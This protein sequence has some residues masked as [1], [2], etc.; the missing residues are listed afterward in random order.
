VAS[1]AYTVEVASFE[2]L[3]ASDESEEIRFFP[4]DTL[5]DIDVP[6]TQRP[7]LE[8]LLSRDPP[9]HLD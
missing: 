5:R 8:R 6:A 3:R 1:F 2:G 9:P 7:V 4:L